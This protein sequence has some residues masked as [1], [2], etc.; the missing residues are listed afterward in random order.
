MKDSRLPTSP[1][2]LR[3]TLWLCLL[4]AGV[5]LVYW[6]GLGGGFAFDDYPNIV[7]N[8]A[9]HVTTLAWRD[10]LSAAF[11]S[12]ATDLQRPLA[13]LT[14]ALQHYFTGLDPRALKAGNIAVTSGTSESAVVIVMR[15]SSRCSPPAIRRCA[16]A[17][18]T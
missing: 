10:W 7:F 12:N 1:S 5:V 16:S 3:N 11:S 2:P 13:M 9:L 6:P 4:L 17:R 15:P 8:Q 18:L 14:F